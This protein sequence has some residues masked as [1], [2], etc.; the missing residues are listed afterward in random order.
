LNSL[1]SAKLAKEKHEITMDIGIL[2]GILGNSSKVLE[3]IWNETQAIKSHHAAP[4]KSVIEYVHGN[5][6]K[7]VIADED[8]MLNSK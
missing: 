3:V 8:L 4:R 2:E 6:T 7:H 1:E 5:G